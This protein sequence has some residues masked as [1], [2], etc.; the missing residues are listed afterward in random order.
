[1]ALRLTA[2]SDCSDATLD[3]AVRLL[4]P[5]GWSATP[6]ALPLTLP[7]GEHRD[8]DVLVSVPPGAPAGLYPVRAQLALTGAETPAA[9]RQVVED[10]CLVT[11]GQCRDADPIHLV[12]GFGGDQRRV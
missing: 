2:A 10:V 8:A 3:S 6:A 1:M 5:D 11:V 9:W 4:C 12:A 7:S